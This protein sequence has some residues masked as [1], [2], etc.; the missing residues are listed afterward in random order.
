MDLRSLSLPSCGRIL[1]RCYRHTLSPRLVRIKSQ[2]HTVT[3]SI[4]DDQSARPRCGAVDHQTCRRG[5]RNR[6][7]IAA[8]MKAHQP[9]S[10]GR[11]GA[12]DK[13][14]RSI[15]GG[16]HQLKPLRSHRPKDGPRF[17][18][19]RRL[20]Q[21]QAMGGEGDILLAFFDRLVCHLPRSRYHDRDA[22]LFNNL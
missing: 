8:C 17:A 22:G 11:G 16:F 4:Q 18:I 13:D 15:S 21:L 5:D 3:R 12:S 20:C 7:V 10:W 6:A 2:T 1:T 14:G 9:R 19:G